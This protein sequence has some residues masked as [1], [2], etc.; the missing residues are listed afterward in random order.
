MTLVAIPAQSEIVKT[1]H[2]REDTK[3]SDD[4]WNTQVRYVGEIDLPESKY[5]S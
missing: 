5:A 3:V 2:L 1:T 4:V